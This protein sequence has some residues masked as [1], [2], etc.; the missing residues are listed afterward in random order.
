MTTG[1]ESTNNRVYSNDKH[2][3][4][5]MTLDESK[6]EL[7]KIRTMLFF[8]NADKDKDDIISEKEFNIYNGPSIKYTDKNGNNSYFYSGLEANSITNEKEKEL[9]QK[10]DIISKDG[11]L[12]EDEILKEIEK[13]EQDKDRRRNVFDK[14][15]FSI[16]GIC[17]SALSIAG[18]IASRKGGSIFTGGMLGLIGG[19]GIGSTLGFIGGK[20]A[21]SL[22]KKDSAFEI[23][24]N[25]VVATENK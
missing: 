23:E 8:N 14:T 18:A 2:L 17:A 19:F 6:T 7:G 13:I 15:M 10:L 4:V 22:T 9:F 5:G 12:T 1:V 21:G 16:A 25:N 24:S 20:I 11:I 3:W